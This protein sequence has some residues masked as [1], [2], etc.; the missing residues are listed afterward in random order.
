MVLFEGIP[1]PE[2]V[3]GGTVKVRP[4]SRVFRTT[5]FGYRTV[6]VERPLRLR[7]QMTPERLQEYEGKL[8]EKLDGNGRGPKRARSAAAQKQALREED[9]LLDDAAAL[10]CSRRWGMPKTTTGT[11]CG[12]ASRGFWKPEAA[13]A[14]PRQA[15]RRSGTPSR[16]P[17][18][19]RYPWKAASVTARSMSRIPG[20]GTRR[21]CPW[22]RTCTRISSGWRRR[23][24]LR[25]HHGVPW[26]SWMR[27]VYHSSA[28]MPTHRRSI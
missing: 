22:A 17:A 8:R 5:D 2:P 20:C 10:S 19:M 26:W 1:V 28:D 21:T 9:G 12:R 27:A 16:N 15:A 7:F 6:T 25:P 18:R 23:N 11:P 13:A 14:I 4:V 24:C 3:D